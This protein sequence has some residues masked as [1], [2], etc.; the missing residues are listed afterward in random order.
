[1]KDGFSERGDTRERSM[2][3]MGRRRLSAGDMAVYMYLVDEDALMIR[4]MGN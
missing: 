4:C 2:L 3:I 1:M